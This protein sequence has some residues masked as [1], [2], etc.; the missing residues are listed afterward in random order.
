MRGMLMCLGTYRGDPGTRRLSRW[1]RSPFSGPG[2]L[3]V[4]AATA[5]APR[6]EHVPLAG[7][8]ERP[9]G[10]A[11]VAARA[12]ERPASPAARRAGGAGH[13]AGA[14]VPAH[15]GLDRAIHGRSA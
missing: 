8:V 6:F 10:A 3:S 11:T 9:P 15:D 2:H 4:A 5:R 12:A 14:A 7:R 13:R 1:R